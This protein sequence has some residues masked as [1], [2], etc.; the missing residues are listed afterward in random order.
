MHCTS[1]AAQDLNQFLII[2]VDVF[3]RCTSLLRNAV[4]PR[5]ERSGGD[6]SQDQRCS[7]SLLRCTVVKSLLMYVR[8]T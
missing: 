1:K 8:H 6:G 2:S 4:P 3:L 5:Q 7:Q